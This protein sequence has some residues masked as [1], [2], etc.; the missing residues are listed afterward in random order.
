MRQVFATRAASWAIAVFGLGVSHLPAAAHE[1]WIEPTQFRVDPG[2]EIVAN[3]RSGV[4]FK[5]GDLPYIP[6][7]VLAGGISDGEDMRS[8]EGIIGD[9]PAITEMPTHSG[10]HVLIYQTV[11]DR[12]NWSEPGKFATYLAG[13][14]L[15]WALDQHHARGLPETGFVEAYSRCAKTLVQVGEPGG[16]DVVTGMPIE[17]VAE[18]NPYAAAEIDA[19]ELP[20]LLLWQGE[21]LADSQIMIFLKG[22]ESEPTKV[23]TG[24]NGIANIP[25]TESGV[26]LLNAV[27]IIPWDE[28]PLDAWHSY[29]ASLTFEIDD[30]L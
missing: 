4:S 5:G 30:Q 23:R 22:S 13:K 9:I 16:G 24:G 8:L 14:G 27:H 29:W 28:Q 15:D 18:M 3:L 11:A 25:I 21:P 7:R 10:L 19:A 26:Y 1:F 12:L 17:L 6:D 2:A 20:V